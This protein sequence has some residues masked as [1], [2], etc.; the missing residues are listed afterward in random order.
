MEQW[1][2]DHPSVSS[3]EFDV[4]D[5]DE[6]MERVLPEWTRLYANLR[7]LTYAKAV[8]QI[9]DAH[10]GETDSPVLQEWPLGIESSCGAT[11]GAVIPSL[12]H[13]LL[14]RPAP[15]EY[16]SI[17][18]ELSSRDHNV[19]KD[20]VSAGGASPRCIAELDDIL[21]SLVRSP[22]LLWQQY[23]NDLCVSLDALRDIGVENKHDVSPRIRMISAKGSRG[24]ARRSNTTCSKS[25]VHCVPTTIAFDGCI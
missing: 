3:F 16:A 12:S 13:E 10:T 5:I 8:Q 17:D 20:G 21:S 25:R 1:S 14:L 9:L 23:G 7:L 4:L 6:I 15:H 11:H 2:C 24:L 19:L 18:S 22:K